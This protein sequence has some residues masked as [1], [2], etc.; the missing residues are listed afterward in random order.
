MLQNTANLHRGPFD[1]LHVTLR[2]MIRRLKYLQK[3]TIKDLE[4]TQ[5]TTETSIILTINLRQQ[6]EH[7]MLCFKHIQVILF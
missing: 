1:G 3:A 2:E 7:L 6:Y 5:I 4:K